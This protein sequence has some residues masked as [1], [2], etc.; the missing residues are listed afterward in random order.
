[1]YILHLFSLKLWSNM[2]HPCSQEL[3]LL[4]GLAIVHL[5]LLFRIL[6]YEYI[7]LSLPQPLDILLF[8]GFC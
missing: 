3:S 1:M 6:L 5:F 7:D 8:S 2:Y 4:M